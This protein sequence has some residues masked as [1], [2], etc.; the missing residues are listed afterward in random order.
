MNIPL[1]KVD[2]HIDWTQCKIAID[3]SRIRAFPRK[4]EIW[5]ASLGINVGVEINGKHR[6]FERPVLVI[7]AFN[8][9]S[10]LVVPISSKIKDN[11]YLYKFHNDLGEENVAVL[12]QM[13]TISDKR[14]IRK[15]QVMNSK[16][17]DQII[18]K[19]SGFL[20]KTETPSSGVSSELP[21]GEPNKLIVAVEK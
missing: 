16:D 3:H 10:F 21:D 19:V 4:K 1:E 20:E 9:D 11:E 6:T 8:A 17:F 5:W 18:S 13:R 12:S 7:K 2:Q 14:F 15:S